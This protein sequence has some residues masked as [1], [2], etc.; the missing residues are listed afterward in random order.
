MEPILV[1]DDDRLMVR[2]LCDLLRRRGFEAD[3][4]HSGEEALAAARRKRYSALLMD[5]RMAGMSGVEALK[6]LRRSRGAPPVLLMTA[7]SATEL[8][9]EAE[10]AGAFRVLA[11]PIP[12]QLLLDALAEVLAPAARVLIVDDDPEFRRTLGD[13]LAERGARSRGVGDLESALAA[14]RSGT[15]RVIL[16]DLKLDGN[17]PA[18]VIRAIRRAAPEVPLVLYSGHL[19]AL[20]ATVGALPDDWFRAVLRKPL[21]PERLLEVLDDPRDP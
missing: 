8:L 5:V 17:D 14:L 6:E 15:P 3:G 2:T 21:A 7:Y 16:L 9:T 19:A 12:P 13:L 11:K 4:A 10:Q 20:D 18:E 1:V